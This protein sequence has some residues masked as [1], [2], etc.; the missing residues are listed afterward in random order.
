[1]AVAGARRG[2]SIVFGAR[3]FEP[4]GVNVAVHEDS[5]AELDRFQ[6]DPYG[7]KLV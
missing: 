2:F 5:E 7:W 1:M 4:K 6:D 3:I